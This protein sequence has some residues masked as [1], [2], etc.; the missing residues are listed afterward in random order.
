L[1]SQVPLLKW[2]RGMKIHPG[3]HVVEGARWHRRDSVGGA[4]LHFRLMS[5]LADRAKAVKAT[6]EDT[7]QGPNWGDENARYFERLSNNPNLRARELWSGV[8]ELLAKLR[9]TKTPI[10]V[11]Y[12][13]SQQLVD[14]GL[15]APTDEL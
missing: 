8:K 9:I 2:A 3:R 7:P 1:L 4:L 15:V 5:D 10:S 14:L 11:R 6:G 13:N 12:R